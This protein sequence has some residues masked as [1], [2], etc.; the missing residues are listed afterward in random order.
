M[1]DFL[2]LFLYISLIPSE[3][4]HKMWPFAQ[5]EV[6]VHINVFALFAN[7]NYKLQLF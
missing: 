4:A 6:F 2:F 3:I 5:F 7:T 1:S